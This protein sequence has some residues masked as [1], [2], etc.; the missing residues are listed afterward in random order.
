MNL[1]QIKFELEKTLLKLEKEIVIGDITLYIQD[2]L[3]EGAKVFTKDEA[4]N[5]VPV[6]DGTFEYES[7]EYT[8]VAG[9]IT[10]IKDITP[11]AEVETET[12]AAK[13]ELEIVNND[14]EKILEDIFNI[15]KEQKLELSILKEK[16]SKFEN[17]EVAFNQLNE[18]F[19]KLDEKPLDTP[20]TKDIKESGAEKAKKMLN[21]K[22]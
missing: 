1:K 3:V 12:P 7:K 16:I 2:E 13:V 4:G 15:I 11:E 14:N 21:L 6:P 18:K 17:L 10:A 22:K 5:L 9:V 8:V 19:S 20:I